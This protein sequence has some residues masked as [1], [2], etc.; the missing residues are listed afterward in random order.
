MITCPVCG[1]NNAEINRFCQN[2]GT[3]IPIAENFDLNQVAPEDD[4]SP[5]LNLEVPEDVTSPDLNPEIPTLKLAHLSYAALSD[6]G[7]ERQ[8][9]EDGYRCLSQTMTA[10]RQGETAAVS[11]RGLFILCD[12]MGG[13]DGGE[14]ASAMTLDSIAESFKP[15]WTSGLPGR[16]SLTEII[17]IAN[18]SVYDRNQSELRQAMGRMG[19][20]VVLLVIHNNEVAIAH[21][22]DS[23]IYK[24]TADGINQITRDHEVANQLI[25]QGVNAA[26]ALS[27]AD[28]H[29]L[30]QALGPNL[31]HTLEPSIEFLQLE[32]TTLFLL[33]SDGLSDNEVIEDHWQKLLLPYLNQDADLQTGVTELVAIANQINGYDNISAIL[34]R[35]AVNP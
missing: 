33:C 17:A 15:F 22:G 35:C 34:V 28:A 11:Q 2:C 19:T 27:R 18:Q 10:E 5:D 30:T 24:V 1:F 3:A 6:V 23:R 32:T 9:N 12:G 26:I 29:H 7:K 4:T 13:H 20:T 21:V 25:D 14:V 16:Q 8:H 31:S